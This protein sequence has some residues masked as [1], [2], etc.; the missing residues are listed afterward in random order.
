MNQPMG[1]DYFLDAEPFW[2][3]MKPRVLFFT[4]GRTAFVESFIWHQEGLSD[5]EQKEDRPRGAIAITK[6]VSYRVGLGVLWH[7]GTLTLLRSCEALTQY[8]LSDSKANKF[9]KNVPASA[10]RKAER[11]GNYIAA[12]QIIRTS[13]LSE[14]L[15]H[16]SLAIAEQMFRKPKDSPHLEFAKTNVTKHGSKLVASCLG[17][18]IGT[19]LVPGSGTWVGST[20]GEVIINSHMK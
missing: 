11:N 8:L 19:L 17:A 5:D 7:V 9:V 20:V 10:V 3:H 16:M 18:S 12:Y 14:I 6:H 1:K 2:Q 15:T 4:F 13:I